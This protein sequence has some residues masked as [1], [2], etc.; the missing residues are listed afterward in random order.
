MNDKTLQRIRDV[1]VR[2]YSPDRIIL[3]GSRA[4][5]RPH[6]WSDYDMLVLKKGVKSSIYRRAAHI[7]KLLRDRNFW[8]P[9]DVFVYNQKELNSIVAAGSQ[10]FRDIL[11]KGKIMYDKP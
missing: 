10:L 9:M 2:E 5:G 1:I 3:F 4:W 8:Q 7:T 6:Q 11:Q